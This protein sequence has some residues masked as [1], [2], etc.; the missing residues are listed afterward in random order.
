MFFNEIIKNL[1][2]E[3]MLAPF[4]LSFVGFNAILVEGHF[5]IDYFSSVKIVLTFKKQKLFLYG[6][7]LTLKNMDSTQMMLTGK[8][9]GVF[10]REI[11]ID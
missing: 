11:K 10:D 9:F 1:K 5:A 3:D 2:Q 8:I 6:Q 7:N 4:S